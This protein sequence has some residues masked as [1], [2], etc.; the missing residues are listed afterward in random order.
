MRIVF[1]LLSIL[2]LVGVWYSTEIHLY[3]QSTFSFYSI[4]NPSLIQV[5]LAV[6]AG[7]FATKAS[8]SSHEL[9]KLL[10]VSDIQILLQKADTAAS[11]SKQ[12]QERLDNLVNL[13]QYEVEQQ[14]AR[15]M[16]INHRRQML[17]H[18]EQTVKLEAI[19]DKEEKTDGID[20]KIRQQ[21]KNY[22]LRTQYIEYMGKGFLRGIPVFGRLLDYLI[23]PL[24]NAYY[25]RNIHKFNKFLRKE[26]ANP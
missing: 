2:S 6:L 3:I 20:P 5:L 4:Q 17:Y 22:V 1:W 23:G 14:F 10:K 11:R 15:E 7:I 26:K 16:L 19:F 24:W 13:V 25:L 18:W 9:K 8:D 12:E 21:I